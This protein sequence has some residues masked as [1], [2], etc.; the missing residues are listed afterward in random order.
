M[1]RMVPLVAVLVVVL[2]F[3][4]AARADH[5]DDSP[6]LEG[7]WMVT[8]AL[9]D[10]ATGQPHGAPFAS[11]LSFAR[12][13]TLVETTANPAFFPALRSSGHGIWTREG[14]S[15]YSASSTAFITRD[16]VLVLTQTIAQSI[17]L[18]SPDAFSSVASIEFHDPA[19]A[20]VRKG[21]ATAAA[22]RYR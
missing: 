3:T 6:K 5:D 13:G 15:S 17:E 20:L 8:V 14:G 18:T 2:G 21:C 4:R 9:A 10:C 1:K 19:G 22:Q 11:M 7:T 16:G 12:G